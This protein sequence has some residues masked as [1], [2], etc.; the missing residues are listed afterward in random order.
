[1]LHPLLSCLPL[2]FGGD[3]A[4]AATTPTNSAESAT[5]TSST[6]R[7]ELPIELVW[8]DLDAD[9]RTDLYVRDPEREDRLL[10]NLGDGRF[11]DVTVSRAL[12]GLHGT[13]RVVAADF[14]RDGRIDLVVL[15][16]TAPMRLFRNTS[17]GFVDVAVELGTLQRAPD[18]EARWL[19]FDQDGWLDLELTNARAPR[20]LRNVEGQRF[21]RVALA[22]NST[23]AVPNTSNPPASAALT[24][25]GANATPASGTQ[26]LALPHPRCVDS[27]TDQANLGV[28][29]SA[30]SVPELGLLMPLSNDFFVDALG[31]VGLGTIRPNARLD[32]VGDVLATSFAGSG[33]LLTNLDAGAITS[34]TLPDERL[35]ADLMRLSGAQSVSGVKTF[36]AAPS[37]NAAG[38]PFQV[39]SNTRV[40]NLNADVL[41]GFDSAA[42]LR[43]IPVPLAL[44]GSSSG[45]VS[46][47]VNTSTAAGAIGLLGEASATS[48]TR[49]YG[50]VGRSR[51]RDGVGVYGEALTTSST[52]SAYGGFFECDGAAGFGV[53]ARDTSSNG[54]YGGWFD[55]QGPASIAL[56]G[57]A[58][59]TSGSAT[60]IGVY[61]RN[62]S[63]GANAFAGLFDGRVHVNGLLSKSGGSF[64]IDH[65]LDP[66]HKTLSHSF[67][68]SPDMMNVYN[69]NVTT[70]ANGS[71]TV[72]L[73]DWFEALNEKF[74]YQL[75]VIDENDFA[76]VRIE[77]GVEHNRFSIRTDRGNVLVS[78]Q[79]TGVRKDAWAN[80][81]RIPVEEEKQ[82][83]LR[84]RYLNPIENGASAELG[85]S[86]LALPA[87]PRADAADPR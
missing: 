43:S 81:H 32:V 78:W 52:G 42:F 22:L 23:P 17:A 66:A 87:T 71:A 64:K 6:D 37:F 19:D 33:A 54:G 74:R 56:A 10:A 45:A 13:R 44:S 26:S 38:V 76:R 80:A 55:A 4:P 75:T 41:D 84:G 86:A 2:A 60:S 65:P 70:D 20:L 63:S 69:G 11:E 21:E 50:I 72:V 53:Y 73:P 7:G 51:T 82:G 61:G 58:N 68:E 29:I 12:A 35:P 59:S 62:Q 8:L 9:G 79:V 1:M 16:A 3:P 77:H 18:L 31:H 48:A 24:T 83:E 5:E 30:S 34:G 57:S 67:V 47:H 28:C 46:A 14:D 85:V 40:P 27:V 39:A 36:Q 25:T 15:S 49:S